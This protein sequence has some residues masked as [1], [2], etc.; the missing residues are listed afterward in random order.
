LKNLLFSVSGARGVIGEGLDPMVFTSLAA[1]FGIWCGG[2][3]IVVGRD[4]R[5][6][7]EMAQAAVTAGLLGVGCDVVDLGIVATPTVEVAVRKLE[8]SGGI[9]ISASHNPEQWNALKLLSS[10]GIFLTD[11]EG[12]ALK[13]QIDAGPPVFS[14]WDKLGKRTERGDL[15]TAHIDRILAFS[16]LDAERIRSHGIVAVVDCVAGA[17]GAGARQLLDRLGVSAVWIHAEPTGR[18]PRNPEP[19]AEHLEE[20]SRGVRAARANIGFALD[21]DADRVAV[22]DETGNPIGEERTLAGVIDSF[23]PH[24]R[25]DVVVN[26]ST[27][28]AIDDIA[29]R[30]GV[31][32]HRTPVGEV[33]V[34]EKMLAL[35]ARIGGEGNGGIIVPEVNPGRDAFLGMA[36]W[37]SAMARENAKV[38][39][40]AARIPPTVMRKEKIEAKDVDWNR[41]VAEL[42]RGF[43]AAKAETVDGLKLL[44]DDGWVHV[45]KSNTEPI[46]RLLAEARTSDRVEDLVRQARGFIE[47]ARA[48]RAT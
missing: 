13:A 46:V 24:L 19:L 48:A 12:A 25:S 16:P 35:G 17:G 32:V 15:T 33:H 3:R 23:L 27:T 38:S 22:V 42:R 9:Q 14:T 11:S 21:P 10:R 43:P 45:R 18:F 47:G 41:A 40:L 34:T 6:S 20:L 36:L 31:R 29:A 2:G 5:V 4:S 8:A 44:F 39:D 26:V 7:G 37:L 30:H 1:H 28:M